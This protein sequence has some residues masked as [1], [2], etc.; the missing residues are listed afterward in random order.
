LSI[1]IEHISCFPNWHV[2]TDGHFGE[3]W[4]KKNCGAGRIC[5]I[6]FGWVI[7][8]V[9][10]DWTWSLT[11]VL[12]HGATASSFDLS[13]LPGSN[14]VSVMK[15]SLK[16]TLKT[17]LDVLHT[18]WHVTHF[19]AHCKS[20]IYREHS[21]NNLESTAAMQAMEEETADFDDKEERDW[22]TSAVKEERD[23]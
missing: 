2:R 5:K 22:K 14:L 19:L 3:G 13:H 15:S 17:L 16:I 11:F 9:V 18:F 10:S 1:Y 7:A 4:T 21:S 23:L 8:I 12:D 20:T 6:Q